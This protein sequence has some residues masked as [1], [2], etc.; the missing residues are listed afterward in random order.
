MANTS[1]FR[2]HD[3]AVRSGQV[4]SL[5][6]G[7]TLTV[8]HGVTFVASGTTAPATA[9]HVSTIETSQ[10]GTGNQTVPQ[11]YDVV[12]D[13]LLGP[14][15]HS[16]S[17][18]GVAGLKVHRIMLM[19]GAS[20]TQDDDSRLPST[21]MWLATGKVLTETAGTMVEASGMRA[22]NPQFVSGVQLFQTMDL[23][24]RGLPAPRGATPVATRRY[25]GRFQLNSPSYPRIR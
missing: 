10:L 5:R 12:S 6:E 1:C 13:R 17:P 16:S 4:A 25:S 9:I 3:I 11:A 20:V 7:A 19:P 18:G 14:L 8:P 22:A 21:M 2:Q 23:P 15:P 24:I